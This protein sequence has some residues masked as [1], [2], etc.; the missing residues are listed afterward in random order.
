MA[1]RNQH[2]EVHTSDLLQA[3]LRAKAMHQRQQSG[4]DP[5]YGARDK[6]TEFMQMMHDAASLKEKSSPHPSSLKEKSSPSSGTLTFDGVAV[7]TLDE[8]YR[9]IVHS[10]AA[11]AHS[12]SIQTFNPVLYN[13]QQLTPML[14]SQLLQRLHT[15]SKSDTVNPTATINVASKETK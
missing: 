1:V 14:M 12:P 9:K 5:Y 7:S 11:A 10:S 13:Q 8:A 2:T 15:Q 3:V 4:Q 6:D